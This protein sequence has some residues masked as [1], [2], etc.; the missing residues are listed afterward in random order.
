MEFEV[1]KRKETEKIGT[2]NRTRK[3]VQEN[4]RKSVRKLNFPMKY[5]VPI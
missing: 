1:R 2:R 5:Q 4:K 3:L